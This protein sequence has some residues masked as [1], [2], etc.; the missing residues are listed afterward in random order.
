MN[1]SE[2]RAYWVS[3]FEKHEASGLSAAAFCRQEGIQPNS[4]YHWRGRL[5]KSEP[6][7]ENALVPVTVVG[8]SAVEVD[9]PCGATV[10]IPRDQRLL[11]QVLE[12]LVHGETP[13]DA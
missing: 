3:I 8:E 2:R 13:S 4:F 6:P 12:I 5:R 7:A 10:R 1:S 9:L 11:R